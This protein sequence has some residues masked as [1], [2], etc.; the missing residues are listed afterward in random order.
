MSANDAIPLS[1]NK[2]S[3]RDTA[4]DRPQVLRVSLLHN[5]ATSVPDSEVRRVFQLRRRYREQ[6]QELET[7]RDIDAFEARQRGKAAPPSP[8]EL[9]FPSDLNVDLL[10][11]NEPSSAVRM[12]TT[13]PPAR[14]AASAAGPRR[15]MRRR[16]F[17]CNP[18]DGDVVH[19]LPTRRRN[20]TAHW[21]VLD[22]PLLPALPP[23]SY[24]RAAKPRPFYLPARRSTLQG[25]PIVVDDLVDV[26]DR[27]QR[28]F[29][30]TMARAARR[31]DAAM[32]RTLQARTTHSRES[33]R[34]RQQDNMDMAQRTGLWG[35]QSKLSSQKN[36]LSMAAWEPAA[37]TKEDADA[38]RE[39][40]KYDD[41]LWSQAQMLRRRD[42][43]FIVEQDSSL[44]LGQF[45]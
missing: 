26:R 25:I 23:T 5:P 45:S 38:L 9:A 42:R 19:M 4:D 29:T 11:A 1:W 44:D 14:R 18:D 40:A 12:Y 28:Q 27:K 43:Q 2:A 34:K 35:S 30:Q 41:A 3:S 32:R 22:E 6:Q 16:C 7:R 31:D 39:L 37:P 10:R 17:V 24:A 21:Q 36:M 8:P 33:T 20:G 13:A 15:S